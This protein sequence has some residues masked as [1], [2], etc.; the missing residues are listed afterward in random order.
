M[1]NLIG[2]CP[3]FHGN[4][5]I[6]FVIYFLCKLRS[7]LIQHLSIHC[8][9]IQIQMFI[10]FTFEHF[11]RVILSQRILVNIK[12]TI[13]GIKN[14]L[15]FMKVTLSRKVINFLYLL[16]RCLKLLVFQEILQHLTSIQLFLTLSVIK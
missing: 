1:E 13:N 4:I 16:F 7:S 6:E 12:S 10:L 14:I 3:V 9:F 8:R 11:T 2:N 5:L 15:A